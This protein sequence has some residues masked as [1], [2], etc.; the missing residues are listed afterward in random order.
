[1]FY[2]KDSQVFCER[3]SRCMASQNKK[4]CLSGDDKLYAAYRAVLKGHQRSPDKT[5]GGQVTKRKVQKGASNASTNFLPMIITYNTF[6]LF[7]FYV[8]FGTLLQRSLAVFA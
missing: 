6:T 7:T 2:N 8:V 4:N 5:E 1:M 3:A